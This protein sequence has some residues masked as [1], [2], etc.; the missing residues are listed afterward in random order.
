MKSFTTKKTVWGVRELARELE[1]SHTKIFRILETMKEEG[2]V[3]QNP[4]TKKYSLGSPFIELGNVAKKQFN[5]EEALRPCLIELR[6][7]L[8]ES[9]FLT[10]INKNQGRTLLAVDSQQGVKFTAFEGSLE[11]LYAGASYRAILAYQEETFI[12]EI[13]SEKM[14]PYTEKTILDKTVHYKKLE[15]IKQKGYAISYGEY[16]KDVCAIAYPIKDASK[17][18]RASLTISGPIYRISDE[19]QQLA[20]QLGAKIQQKIELILERSSIYF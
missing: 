13:L 1:Q 4:E 18:V 5:L 6:D 16:T 20:L 3:I 15:E 9:I 2:F 10:V 17:K 12:D 7:A 8:D 19:K 14:I 11:P